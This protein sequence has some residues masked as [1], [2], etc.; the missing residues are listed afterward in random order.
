MQLIVAILACKVMEMLQASAEQRLSPAFTSVASLAGGQTPDT[1]AASAELV[2]GMGQQCKYFRPQ[3]HLLSK[4]C[5]AQH[6]AS[7][8]NR[9][10]HLLLS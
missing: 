10:S 6:D 1:A 2:T 8:C 3:S 9:S 7:I 4:A 5:L